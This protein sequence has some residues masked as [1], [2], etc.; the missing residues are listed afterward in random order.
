MSIFKESLYKRTQHRINSEERA[1]N[2]DVTFL[3]LWEIV[4]NRYVGMILIELILRIVML[5][6]EGEG[7]MRF[8]IIPTVHIIR[9]NAIIRKEVNDDIANVVI[10][11]LGDK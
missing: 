4:L 3:H 9:R 7:Y 2:H 6:K 1:E 5:V 11:H 10:S 8:G